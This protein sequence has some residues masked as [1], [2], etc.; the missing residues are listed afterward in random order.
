MHCVQCTCTAYSIEVCH[1]K[2]KEISHKSSKPLYSKRCTEHIEMGW[3][4]MRWDGSD[5]G[6]DGERTD[7]KN[8]KEQTETKR[9]KK[10]KEHIEKEWNKIK[11]YEH[12]CTISYAVCMFEHFSTRNDARNFCSPTHFF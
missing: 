6:R 9:A 3:D 2:R 1:S 12:E 8:V 4:G 5:D 7:V 11:Q 10:K